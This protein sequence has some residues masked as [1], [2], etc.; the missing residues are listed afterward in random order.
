METVEKKGLNEFSD[1]QHLLNKNTYRSIL[2]SN[3]VFHFCVSCTTQSNCLK[4]TLIKELLFHV[5]VHN[6]QMRS[7]KTNS[8]YVLPSKA[9]VIRAYIVDCE[10]LS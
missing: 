3:F 1:R 2:E 10:F 6:L 8:I 4:I 5:V 7:L 9:S